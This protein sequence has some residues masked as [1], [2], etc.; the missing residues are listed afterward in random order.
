MEI[1]RAREEITPGPQKEGQTQ[2]TLTFATPQDHL[3]FQGTS[4]SGTGP[5]PGYNHCAHVDHSSLVPQIATPFDRLPSYYSKGPN[6]TAPSFQSGESTSS[7]QETHPSGVQIIRNSLTAR[8]ISQKAAKVILQSWRESTHK[9]YSVYLRKWVLFC[10]SRGFDPYKSTPAQALD[11]MT[12]LFEQGLGYS[13]MN[14]VRSALSQVLHSPTGVSFG[15]LPTVKQFLKGVFQEKPTLPRYSVTWDP[16]ILLSYLKTLS[17]VKELTL[18]ML[19]YKTVALLGLLSAQRC[20]TLF[21]LDIRNMVINS[22]TVKISIGDKLKQTKPGKHVHELEFPAYPTDI[23]LC[24]VDVMKEYLER[25]KPLRG[26]ITSLFVTYV[27]PYKAA[28]KDTISRWIKTTLK[29][30]GI[31]MT[32]F[33]PHSIRSSSTS[34]AAIAKVPVD[35]ILRTAGWSGHCTFAKYY[36]KPIQNHGALAKALLDSTQL[37]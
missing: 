4:E 28:S 21:F 15:E 7:S 27:K 24:I 32:R 11:F 10:S 31:D 5:E 16:A 3:H 13:A 33:K 23:C 25:T 20:Q 30:A 35:T 2:S 9:Q 22:S 37:G 14:T 29:L 36:K 6:N 26:D 8:G 34:A 1:S 17:P 19:T 12:D 18:K